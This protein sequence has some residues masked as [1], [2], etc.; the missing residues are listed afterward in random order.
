ML[1]QHVGNLVGQCLGGVRLLARIEPG[2]C[3]DDL[4]PD[5]RIDGLGAEH[6]V[7]PEMT[8]LERGDVAKHAPEYRE[9]EIRHLR[10]HHHRRPAAACATQARRISTCSGQSLTC[11]AA[12][13]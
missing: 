6:L 11:Q 3:S 2:I 4:D 13:R 7:M 9:K 8:N 10:R 12:C 1:P 5:V